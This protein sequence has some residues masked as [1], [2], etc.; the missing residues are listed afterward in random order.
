[1]TWLISSMYLQSLQLAF[2]APLPSGSIPTVCSLRCRARK[3]QPSQCSAHQCL[4]S[5]SN[6]GLDPSGRWTAI[7][8]SP[9][10]SLLG[11]QC[12]YITYRDGSPPWALWF[13]RRR[14]FLCFAT[15][16]P[17]LSFFHWG[18]SSCSPSAPQ[19]TIY[20][21]GPAVGRIVAP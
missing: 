13:P 9:K 15:H 2:P 12:S 21:K 6:G 16:P 20:Y 3:V 1:M 14:S 4:S 7:P 10:V 8:V 11:L 5:T 19:S 18:P 17:T